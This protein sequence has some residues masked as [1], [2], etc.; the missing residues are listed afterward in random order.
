MS[1]SIKGLVDRGIEVRAKLKK[2]KAEL[3]E[4]EG[5]LQAAGL[6]R[7]HEYLKDDDREGR[8]WMARGSELVVPVVFTADKIMGSFAYN[9][10]KHSQ[11]RAIA[12]DELKDFY[13]L[14]QVMENQFDDGKKFRLQAGEILGPK[15]PAFITA[16][17]ARDKFGVPKSDVRVCWDDGEQVQSPESK[18]QSP[19]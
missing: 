9:S 16:C 6:E 18:V 13:K 17:L 5:K 11:A 19:R 8:R 4:I 14:K 2:L 10:P 7:E 3:D 15:A 12:G 1:E